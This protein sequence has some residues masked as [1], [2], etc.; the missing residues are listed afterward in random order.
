[1]AKEAKQKKPTIV[2]NAPRSAPPAVKVDK[3]MKKPTAKEDQQRKKARKNQWVKDLKKQAQKGN[4]KPRA[5]AVEGGKKEKKKYTSKI[6]SLLWNT[7]KGL[8]DYLIKKYQRLSHQKGSSTMDEED[9]P[10]NNLDE[11]NRKFEDRLDAIRS[12]SLRDLK[13]LVPFLLHFQLQEDLSRYWKDLESDE[14]T[15]ANPSTE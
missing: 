5:T 10:K 1:M 12:V 6:I 15:S 7:L 11:K 3:Q 13:L 2:A 4:P 8:R 14:V 9:G